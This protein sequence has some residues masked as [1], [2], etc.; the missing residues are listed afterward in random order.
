MSSRAEAQTSLNFLTAN[1]C[2]LPSKILQAVGISLGKKLQL[3]SFGDPDD[4]LTADGSQTH[5]CLVAMIS[6][7]KLKELFAVFYI[8]MN[9]KRRQVGTSRDQLC[10]RSHL[11]FKAL[12]VNTVGHILLG[13]A[14]ALKEV[15]RHLRRADIIS[16]KKLQPVRKGLVATLGA[17]IAV[18]PL[19]KPSLPSVISCR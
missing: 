17:K 2:L 1:C 19:L 13:T 8:I 14:Y 15:Q 3:V 12:G 11:L 9:D 7:I 6:V 10:Q 16:V 5:K 4:H 18:N